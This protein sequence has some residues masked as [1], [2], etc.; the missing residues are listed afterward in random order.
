VPGLT[1]PGSPAAMHA[2]AAMRGPM[3][4]TRSMPGPMRSMG[5]KIVPRQLED[6][7]RRPMIFHSPIGH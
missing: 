1:I 6:V 5:R 7:A 2:M 4:A 3:H